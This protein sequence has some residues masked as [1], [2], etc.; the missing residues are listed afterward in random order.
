MDAIATLDL[1]ELTSSGKRSFVRVEVGR[2]RLNDQGSWACPVL[3]STIDE[4]VRD[5]QGE[6]SMQALC[7]ALS[8]AH[9]MLQSV[10]NRGSRLL[11]PQEETDFALDAYFGENGQADRLSQPP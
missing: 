1:V 5:I 11:Y 3:I 8:F 2:P 9:D 6:D 4:K 7:L 10:L